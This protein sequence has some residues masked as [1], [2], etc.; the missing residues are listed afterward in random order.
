MK[1]ILGKENTD[2][3]WTNITVGVSKKMEKKDSYDYLKWLC[4]NRINRMYG[5]DEAYMERLKSELNYLRDNN[6]LELYVALKH[7]TW[8]S[9]RA[10]YPITV[11]EIDTA[12]M[13][14]FLCGIC[15]ENPLKVNEL[16]NAD[17]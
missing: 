14:A 7:I 1:F 8:R 16:H 17:I 4:I 2:L 6:M 5:G 11:Q 13:V 12:Q 10:G 9:R 15:K 3:I